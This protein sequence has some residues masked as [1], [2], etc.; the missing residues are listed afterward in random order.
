MT[1]Y[2]KV[3]E[4]LAPRAHVVRVRIVLRESIQAAVEGLEGA[5]VRPGRSRS[6]GGSH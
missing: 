5:G 6:R 4:F 1:T 2:Q 3:G